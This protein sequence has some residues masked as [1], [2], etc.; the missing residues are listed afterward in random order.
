MAK[1]YTY[2]DSK[3]VQ[4][5]NNELLISIELDKLGIKFKKTEFFN[6][7]TFIHSVLNEYNFVRYD[8]HDIDTHMLKNDRHYHNHDEARMIVKG[9]GVFYFIVDDTKIEL[10]VE[11]GTFIIIPKEMIHY[12]KTCD[13]MTVLRFFSTDEQYE[14]I[15]VKL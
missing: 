14:A 2:E 9:D 11:P 12:F 5:I 8:L 10:M 4:F 15:P 3:L 6:I 13:K 7:D 1:L